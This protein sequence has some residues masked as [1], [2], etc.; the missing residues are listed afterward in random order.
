[1]TDPRIIENV[2][3]KNKKLLEM[4]NH[5]LLQINNVKLENRKLNN[6]IKELEGNIKNINN[7]WADDIDEFVE[8]WYEENNEKIDIG[9]IDFKFFNRKTHI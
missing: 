3:D 4:N 8:K 7:K 9:V 5:L 6:K 2:I 1:M